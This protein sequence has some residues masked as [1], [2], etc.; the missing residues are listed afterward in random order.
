ML[1]SPYE[2]GHKTGRPQ[3][4][5]NVDDES[6]M[7]LKRLKKAL[8]ANNGEIVAQALVLME[9][10]LLEIDDKLKVVQQGI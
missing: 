5:V 9:M 4:A 10:L 2:M 6:T 1:L 7:R 3:I 8:P